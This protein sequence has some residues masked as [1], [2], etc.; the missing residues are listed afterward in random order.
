MTNLLQL[1]LSFL[2]V[3]LFSFGGAYSLLPVIEREVVTNNKW[4]SEDEFIQT[5][6]VV[7]T[8]PGAISIK[9]ATY[10]G[11]KVAGVWGI[12]VANFANM[13]TPAVLIMIMTMVLTAYK[14]NAY[15][16]KAIK[17]VKFAV[18]GMIIA[19]LYQYSVKM[20]LDVYG[21]I[22]LVIGIGLTLFFKLNPIYIVLIAALISIIIYK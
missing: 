9:F 8:I 1:F 18:I 7:E 6:S 16:T 11:F 20:N 13:I 2:K 14:D 15:L 12:I 3:G 4:L 17:G 22:L 21:L 19:I 5:L 10:T